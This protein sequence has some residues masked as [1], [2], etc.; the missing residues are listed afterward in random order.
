MN[1]R[2]P[3]LALLLSGALTSPAF[4]LIT[5][6]PDDS[7]IQTAPANGAPWDFVGE[8]IDQFGAR[9]SAVYLGNGYMI[10]AD[11]VDSD[12]ST[13]ML[14][15]GQFTIDSTYTPYVI[16]GADLRIF[17]ITQNPG[18]PDMP[19]ITSGEN[20]FNQPATIIGW[21]VGKGTPIPNQGWN[22]GDDTTRLERWGTN[23][24]MGSYYV[25]PVSGI[26]YLETAF[27]SSV[28]GTE[29]QLTSGD[30]GGG[31][32]IKYGNTWTLAAINDSVSGTN[33]E[34]LYNENPTTPAVPD[35][36]YFVA[37]SLYTGLIDSVIGAAGPGGLVQY[38]NGTAANVGSVVGGSGTWNATSMNW[39]GA[40][41]AVN[42]SWQS[43]TAI[44]S[45]TAGTVTLGSA[46]SAQSLVFDT[47]GYVVTGPYTLTMTGSAPS[48]TVTSAGDTATINVPLAG[49]AGLTVSGAG[50]LI[51]TSTSSS[52]TGA[53]TVN[54]ATLQLGT[55]TAAGALGAGTP[56][57]LTQ[58]GT[59]SLV[60]L[61]GN[62]FANAVST[63]AGGGALNVQSSNSVTLSGAL[64]DDGVNLLAL[65][66]AGSGATILTNAHNT[67]SGATTISAG[68]LQIGA[69]SVAGSIG[70]NSAVTVG[71]GNLSLVNVSGGN[72]ANSVTSAATASGT[73][74]VNSPSA[75]TLS[76]ILAN[77]AGSTLA[78]TQSGTGTT[79]L[80]AANTFTG[81]ITVTAGALQVG[82]GA[83]GTIAAAT[84]VSGSASLIF[85]TP[86]GAT[87]NSGITLT[88][89]STSLKFIQ[90]G[91]L[92]LDG[93][94]T[95]T[96][97]IV[98][99][100]V[101]TT[102]LGGTLAIT[103]P[104]NITAGTLQF[105]S[106]TSVTS[107][108]S[109]ASAGTLAGTANIHGNVTVTG[110]GAIDLSGGSISGTLGVTGGSWTG[111]GTVGGLVTVSSGTLAIGSGADLTASSGLTVSGGTL[112][113]SGTLIGSLAY[114]T[115][116]AGA[117]AGVI[118][119]G[120]SSSSLT[121]SGASTLILTGAN[122]YSGP[123]SITAGALQLG[124]G[125][126]ANSALGSAPVTVSGSGALAL[127][128][129]SG[130]T[131][132]NNVALSAGGASFK[133]VQSG[134]NTVAGVLSGTGAF[135]QLGTGVTILDNTNTYAG[136]TTIASGA[137][138]VDGS[139]AKGSAVSVAAA[140]ALTGA[141]SIG[142]TVTV[143]SGGTLSPGDPSGP[144][145]LTIGNLVLNA[146]A[147]SIF[148]LATPGAV[149][150]GVNDL[151]AVT[152][153]LT[154][155]GN[156]NITQL[157]GFGI[158]SYTL[159]T[160]GG[161]LTNSGSSNVN[162]TGGFNTSLSTGAA[163]QVNLVVSGTAVTQYWDGSNAANNGVIGGGSGAWNTTTANWTNAAGTANSL[164]S[165]GTA[166]FESTG[167]A[168]TIGAPLNVQGLIF[169]VTGFT[170]S[171]ASALHLIGSSSSAPTISVTNP[172]TIATINT[173]LTGASG[174]IANGAGT[175]A[176]T[177]AVNTFT[178]GATVTNGTL[179]IGTPAAVGSPGLGPI[180]VTHGGTL[181]LVFNEGGIFSNTVTNGL[182]GAGAFTVSSANINTISGLL[183][184]G[185]TG[186]LTLSQTGAGTTILTNGGNSYSGATTVSKGVLQIG[187]TSA[188]GSLGPTSTVTVG[189]GGVLTVTNPAGG[190]LPNNITNALSGAGT[191]LINSPGT[192]KLSGSLTSGLGSLAITQ[193]GSGATILTGSD[194]YSGAT[195]V[196]AGTLQLGDGINGA[197]TGNGAITLSGSATL[198]LDLAN[199]AT[200][201]RTINLSAA[202]NTLKGIEPS[203]S[204]DTLSGVISG[205]GGVTQSGLGTLLLTGLNTYTGPTNI[206]TGALENNGSIA[207]GSTVNVAT[208][209][210]LTGNG[211][212]LGKATLTGN[213]SIDL[214]GAGVITGT[215]AV[216]GGNWTGFGTVSGLITSSSG[217]FS[218]ASGATLTATT[219]LSLTGG[220]LAGAGTLTGS[221]TDTSSA[222][223]TFAGVISGANSAVT[224]N[225]SAGTLTL[226]GANTYGKGTTLTAGTLQ[227]GNGVTTGATLG[228]G[229][230]TIASAGTLTTDL[231]NTE[232]LTNNITDNGHVI[233]T[234]STSKYTIS[235]TVSGSG[236]FTKTGVNTVTLTG[237]N[238]FT[239]GTIVNAGALL[240]ANTSGS[241]T[242]TGAVTVNSGGTLGGSGTIHGAVTLNNG[243]DLAPSAGTPG[244]AGTTLS[245]TSLLWNGGGTLT[246]QI[247]ATNDE[248]ALTGALTKGST[249]AYTIDIED[250]GLSV[251]TYTIATFASTTFAQSN[252][253]LDLP[254]GD[255]GNL[256][257]TTT[258]L[259]VDITAANAP[260]SAQLPS[261][262]DTASLSTGPTS[263]D[264]SSPNLTPTPEPT[265][266][267]LLFLGGLLLLTHR[268][269]KP[270]SMEP[271]GAL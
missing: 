250:V 43:G 36:S 51:L 161:T 213:G 242:G 243:A 14:D 72:F 229:N 89:S 124:D 152:G 64:T 195:T 197:L 38:W 110:N 175:L 91:A 28:G 103:G 4:A 102:V 270:V 140:A 191:V 155:A 50:T 235:S 190:L 107:T 149:G 132:S 55:A 259:S 246:L 104:I 137:L 67:F 267:A 210:T 74:L 230:V 138:Q 269:R 208:A 219:G 214:G 148:R 115:S 160:Y 189:S 87:L 96:G 63:A 49:T 171:G 59:L 202:A 41:G 176:L 147:N 93:P 45:G 157:P 234:G 158:G 260:T 53:T 131:F 238:T 101:G 117:F 112:A 216:T 172:G 232:T 37:A 196:S 133:A 226:T 266:P 201:S 15:G 33:G 169:G 180:T 35:D 92:T 179:Q 8:L 62:T 29:A 257:E 68:L 10:T 185:A 166:V 255:T 184:D 251:A 141:G 95:S 144:G 122:T 177:Y 30:S 240:V 120:P 111:Q 167:G 31:L 125:A 47:S 113:G 194:S 108:V 12:V 21:G 205:P 134:A 145:T 85:D 222:G 258:S 88:G 77:G 129:S 22:Y 34:A 261:Q 44:F 106:A 163:H 57:T 186:Q 262:I 6:G 9:G 105:A 126:T 233:A 79:T 237:A 19:L 271:P 211:A 204:A 70:P 18:L 245:A 42:Y 80:T 156:L 71:G 13:V 26:T 263:P 199:S 203:G 78:F 170:L 56:I 127:D 165:S 23:T 143:A 3:F 82:N 81:P 181:D 248:L 121:K 139:L 252:F 20:A 142:G 116:T 244:T 209:G 98:Q 48:I 114:S 231:A 153:N 221:L 151:V 99:N 58:G 135:S 200:V 84:S 207:A 24:T 192:I 130:S 136:A 46:V 94:I 218:I 164:W 215:L 150:G 39:T 224:M 239:G 5:I 7:T 118:A 256:V 97:T 188:A 86:A 174:F 168:V 223:S 83:T 236:N 206:T 76:G 16:Q 17:R 25:D 2:A 247:G 54:G 61:S 228:S 128:L 146:G 253:T 198:A 193:S 217:A 32:F 159:F 27:D 90:A 11:H 162:G 52:Y 173:P 249:G 65:T 225:A 75:L 227:L 265:G 73:I 212:I 254:S 1:P 66:Q 220:A 183:S 268:R 119:D 123:T 178:G 241:G 40:T 154:L 187:A 60:N 264:L 109:I 100:G 182:G 69:G